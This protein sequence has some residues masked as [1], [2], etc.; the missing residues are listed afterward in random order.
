MAARAKALVSP[1]EAAGHLT[2]AQRA[3]LE[4]RLGR[5][6]G[7]SRGV[8]LGY[9]QCNLVVLPKA[10][11]YDFLVYCQRNHRACPI[12]EILDVGDW[13]PRHS[14][15]DADLRTDLPRYAIYRRGRRLADET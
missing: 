9:V 10:F 8:A 7:T 11:A 3:R 13:V 15:P 14:A 1:P 5:H 6:S 12:I 4:N 2:E